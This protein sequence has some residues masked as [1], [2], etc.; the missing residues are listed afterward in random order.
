MVRLGTNFK[1]TFLSKFSRG[2]KGVRKYFTE[3]LEDKT[4]ISVAEKFST[5]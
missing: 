3:L 5:F 2:K 1:T 4:G